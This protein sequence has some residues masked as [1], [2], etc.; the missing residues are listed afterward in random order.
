LLSSIYTQDGKYLFFAGNDSLGILQ[1][2]VDVSA[3]ARP[4]DAQ[5]QQF[6][7]SGYAE[8]LDQG[9]NSDQARI[10]VSA[11]D[12]AKNRTLFTYDS[13]TTR[14]LNKW[15]HLTDTF[16]APPATRFIRVRMIA[17]RHVGGDNDGYF[18]NLTLFGETRP[19]FFTGWRLYAIIGL[20]LIVIGVV[21]FRLRSRRK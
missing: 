19:G 8:S 10:T 12:G 5:Q 1:Q 15:L 13:D 9:P 4:I 14:S 16:T 3:Y 6:S 17:I 11:L 7:F 18:D 2:D 20:C 21:V